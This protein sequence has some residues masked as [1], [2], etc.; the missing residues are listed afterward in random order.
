MA[1]REY[2]RRAMSLLEL[3]SVVAILGLVTLATASYYGHASMGNGGAEGLTRKMALA[4]V[5]ARRATIS[6]GD[7]HY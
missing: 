1:R 5:H 2:S 3:M 6:T 7:N 4:L